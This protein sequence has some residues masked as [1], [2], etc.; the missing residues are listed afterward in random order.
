M[1]FLNK[2][3][4]LVFIF[5]NLNKL[6]ISNYLYTNNTK[7]NSLLFEKIGIIPEIICYKEVI[8]YQTPQILGKVKFLNFSFLFNTGIKNLLI[9][10][11]FLE[12]QF[13]TTLFSKKSKEKW[14]IEEFVIQ[15]NNNTL[16]AYRL[17]LFTGYSFS[18]LFK[19]ITGFYYFYFEHIRNNF[20]FN[21]LLQIIET[22]KSI[23]LLCSFQGKTFKENKKKI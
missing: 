9:T 6:L 3:I 19:V 10:K 5:L 15:E 12:A 21:P 4:I 8:D 20:S 18:Y 7:Q 13:I 11:F 1:K 22:E 14:F 2:I 16:S 17:T 23:G